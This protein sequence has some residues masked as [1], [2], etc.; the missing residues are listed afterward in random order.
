MKIRLLFLSVAA[1]LVLSG[2]TPLLQRSYSSYSAHVESV[3]SDDSSVLRAESYRGLVDAL[4]YYVNRYV[5]QGVIRLSNYS[6]DVATD[7]ETAKLEIMREDPLGAFAVSELTYDFS[8]IVSYYEVT[9]SISYTHTAEEIAAIE[10]ASGAA[11]IRPRLRQ[12]MARFSSS[13]LL[14][15]SYFTG[16]EDQ[17]RAMA[18]QAYHDTPQG[19]FGL[20]EIS[21]SLY[22]DSG[23]QRIIELNF[24]WPES[25]AI[26]SARSEQLLSLARQLLSGAPPAQDTYTPEELYAILLSAAAPTDPD[27]SSDPYAALTGK[28]A[29][30]LARTLALELL[31]QQAEIDA[32]LVSGAA[33]GG[34]SCWLIIDSGS[35][36]RHLL[37]GE[38]APYLY[39]DLEM[40]AA[41]Y[42]WNEDLYPDCV[43]YSAPITVPSPAPESSPDPA[44]TDDG[45]AEAAPG[46]V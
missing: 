41:G 44:V 42:L 28:S 22:P 11:A 12:A 38:D 25:P 3:V 32:T 43:D 20:P 15:T 19:A 10:F 1:A 8:R 6:S 9:V 31:F 35:G 40:S 39:T 2:C 29:N 23:V 36:Y 30:P 18:V 5:T 13:L 24:S 21:V 17:V 4:L 45:S 7:L 34:N 27:G 33:N 37:Q 26:L 16:D 46:S 14:R